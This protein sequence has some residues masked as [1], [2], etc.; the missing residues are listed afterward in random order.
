[1]ES[2]LERTCK[3][4]G[5]A[6]PATDEFFYRARPTSFQSY[7]KRCS[8][9]R[10]KERHLRVNAESVARHKAR[11]ERARL[12]REAVETRKAQR[13][14]LARQRREAVATA[15]A[16][17]AL[18]QCC[19]CGVK[20]PR[21]P[22]NFANDAR[23]CRSCGQ[24]RLER[25]IEASKA[26][27]SALLTHRTCRHCGETKANTL[28]FF[29]PD[30]SNTCKVCWKARTKEYI[31][32]NPLVR[33]AKNQ[34]RRARE[35]NA[36]GRHGAADIRRQFAQQQGLCYWCRGKLETSGDNK[37]HVDHLIA[38]AK[39]GSNGPENIVCACPGCN[40]AKSDKMPWE[41]AGRLL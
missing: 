12:A 10:A 13:A 35:K 26:R 6:F 27:A 9:Q 36:P 38:L 23:Y 5:V 22:K 16:E 8:A 2:V 28:E 21:G 11:V 15:R 14:E 33:R 19:D 18:K 37:F 24:L 29:Y 30:A 3:V 20:F 4:C 40:G 31:R 7:C 34:R 17:R 25:S 41:F 39:G 1:M 32:Q